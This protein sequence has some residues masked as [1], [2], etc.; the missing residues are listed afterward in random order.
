MQLLS[1]KEKNDL[2]HLVSTMVS[3]SITYKNTKS[4]LRH[5]VADYSTLSFDPPISDFIKFKV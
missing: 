3:Y 1:E 5:E 2:A 4:D